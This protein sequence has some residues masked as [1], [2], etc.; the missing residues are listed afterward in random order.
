MT[1]NYLKLFFLALLIVGAS[2]KTAKKTV[3]TTTR[4]D[5]KVPIEV[6][7][8]LKKWTANE[9]KADWLAGDVDVDYKG[10]PLSTTAGMTVRF[11]RDSVVWFNVKKLLLTW[12]GLK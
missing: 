4:P 2:C 6:A 12:R 9:I 10:K 3:T 8:I 7:S 1:I 5:E 11:R